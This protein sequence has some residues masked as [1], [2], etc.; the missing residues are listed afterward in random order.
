MMIKNPIT[1]YK[2]NY[3]LTHNI[4]SCIQYKYLGIYIDNLGRI[5]IKN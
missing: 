1:N 5:P 4:K 3:E 2:L